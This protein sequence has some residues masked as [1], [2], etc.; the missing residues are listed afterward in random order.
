MSPFKLPKGIGNPL[1]VFNHLTPKH[2]YRMKDKCQGKRE[3]QTHNLTDKPSIKPTYKPT[4]PSIK[5]V[6]SV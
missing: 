6:C 5:P 3:V 4:Y 1:L 2:I